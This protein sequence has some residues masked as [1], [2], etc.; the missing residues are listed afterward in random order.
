M[1]IYMY[2]C[3]FLYICIYVH[4]YVFE[5]WYSLMGMYSEKYIFVKFCHCANIPGYLHKLRWLYHHQADLKE[6]ILFLWPFY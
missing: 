3:I 6:Q 2:I 5:V 1:Y 4:I